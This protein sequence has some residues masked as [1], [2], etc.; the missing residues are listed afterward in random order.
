MI[1]DYV[2]ALEPG[3]NPLM[4]QIAAAK[5][6]QLVKIVPGKS[7]TYDL[8]LSILT[9]RDQISKFVKTGDGG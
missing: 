8:E 6:R 1:S 3:T 9:N 5:Q 7:R 2:C 4:G